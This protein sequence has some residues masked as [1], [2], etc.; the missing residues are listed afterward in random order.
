MQPR[1][2][3]LTHNK[4]KCNSITRY[5]KG[6]RAAIQARQSVTFVEGGQQ[7]SPSTL[8]TRQWELHARSIEMHM[9]RKDT[10]NLRLSQAGSFWPLLLQQFFECGAALDMV[11]GTGAFHSA[12]HINAVTK[13]AKP[14]TD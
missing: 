13:Q 5:Q 8:A 10:T 4:Y 7:L 1:G 11:F 14:A 12:R 9:P 2:R 3:A 6:V